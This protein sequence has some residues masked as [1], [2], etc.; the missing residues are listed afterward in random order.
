LKVRVLLAQPLSSTANDNLLVRTSGLSGDE[1]F[2]VVRYEYT[3][4]FD[5]L[6]QVAVGGQGHYW[7]NDHVRLGFTADSNEGGS[8]SNSNLGPADLTL[9]KRAKSWFQLQTS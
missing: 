2:L 1:A 6:D 5:K 3:P 8:A 4:G 9:R 7:L